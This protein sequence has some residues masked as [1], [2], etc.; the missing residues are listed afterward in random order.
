MKAQIKKNKLSFVFHYIDFF[1][2][3]MFIM[4]VTTFVTRLID[5]PHWSTF[6]FAVICLSDVIPTIYFIKTKGFNSL[7]FLTILFFGYF[8]LVTFVNNYDNLGL[9]LIR[10]IR[11]ISF[12]LMICYL[13]ERYGKNRTLK[14]MMIVLEVLN[15]VN[16]FFMIIY[17]NGMYHSVTGLYGD[18][19]VKNSESF[20]RTGT[21]RVH[22]LLGHQTTIIKYVLPA[23]CIAF[24]YSFAVLRKDKLNLRSK[25]LVIVCLL[26][27][28]IAKSATNYV[29]IA[30]C[31]CLYL[32]YKFHIKVKI[33]HIAIGVLF[34]YI[35]FYRNADLV[36]FD[37][38]LELMTIMLGRN[39]IFSR[40]VSIWVNSINAWLSNPIFGHGYLNE[41]DVGV[42][43]ALS[44]GNPHSSYLWILY[45]G[46]LIGLI[47]FCVYLFGVYKGKKNYINCDAGYIL[48]AGF[49][50]ILICMITDDYI[51]R[52]SFSLIFFALIY[53]APRIL[54]DQV[55]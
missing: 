27:V 3:I 22:W 53:Y 21:T 20:V 46:G 51:F 26:E 44:M 23:L 54:S 45:E 33:R 34:L 13:F 38:I 52:D 31:A 43:A 24:L 7:I 41:A 12:I 19:V 32:L 9:C 14:I 18:E 17:P 48:N 35:I 5:I 49:L 2:V 47:L 28:F 36:L 55:R 29:I 10:T 37:S 16:L 15:Y 8:L 4:H 42:W 30:V 1:Y 39:V 25:L 40:R 11:R 50:A 6:C